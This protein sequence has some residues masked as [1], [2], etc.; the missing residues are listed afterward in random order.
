VGRI[1]VGVEVKVDVTF[2]VIVELGSGERDGN[3][4]GML[5]CPLH[6]VS[7][8]QTATE[9]K[10]ILFMSLFCKELDNG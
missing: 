7:S 2:A 1:L 5:L 9:S 6:A 8:M 10:N 4:V 3:E